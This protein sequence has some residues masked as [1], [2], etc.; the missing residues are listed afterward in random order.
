MSVYD[1]TQE[2]QCSYNEDKNVSVWNSGGRKKINVDQFI[3]I[4]KSFKPNIAQCLCDTV[5]SGES[6]KRNRKSVDRTL[7][8][9]DELL[10]CRKNSDMLKSIEILGSVEGGDSET[11]RVRCAVETSKR[12]VAGFV[13]EG[14]EPSS[15]NWEELLKTCIKNLP[16]DR[17][18]FFP[19][20]MTPDHIFSALECGIDVFDSSFAY[21]ATRRGCS[22]NLQ[23]SSKRCKPELN[24]TNDVT[25]KCKATQSKELEEN[26]SENIKKTRFEMNIA[27]IRYKE[28]FSS[29]VIGC[30]CYSCTNHTRAYIYHLLETKEM[31]AEVLL[32]IHNFHQ[33]FSF[34]KKL[35]E[36]LNNDTYETFKQDF[37]RT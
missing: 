36:A 24:H 11:E 5:P 15:Q 34:F 19:G 21:E 4:L 6:C 29:L 14:I 12:E 33:Y 16:S 7:K 32:M 8:F 22:L 23:C 13:V 17:P 1:P 25:E 10:E 30:S 37:L 27:N 20:P 3:E 35:R 31:L 2:I 18:R 9:L 26:I 28:D